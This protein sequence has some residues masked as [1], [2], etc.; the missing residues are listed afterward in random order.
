MKHFLSNEWHRGRARKRGSGNAVVELDALEPRV[1]AAIEPAQVTDPD[2]EFD[3]QWALESTRRAMDTLQ[4][5]ALAKGKTELFEALKGCPTGHETSRCE[6][7]TR[8]GM[9]EGAVK[10]AVH[11]LR[12]R[13]REV[14][15]AQIAETVADPADVDGEM[16]HL[17]AMLRGA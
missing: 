14:L 7:A 12:K 10:V 6:I 1:R 11:R 16:R 17:I 3:R 2:A 13:Y 4:D 15:R 5:E 9:S 8:L